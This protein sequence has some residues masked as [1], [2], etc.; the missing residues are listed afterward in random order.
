VIPRG[1]PYIGWTDLLAA[2]FNCLI[3]GDG[4]AARRLAAAVEERWAPNAVAFLSVR[5]G[6]DALFGVLG[7]PAGSEIV[8]SAITIP[9]ILDILAH[10]RLVA[11][12][13]DVDPE[14]LAVDPTD[15]SRA[16]TPSTKAV[17]VAHLFGSRM[18]LD[19]IAE[20]ARSRGVLLLED[21]AQAND[22]SAYRGHASSDVTMFSFGSIKRQTAMGGG[23]LV[24]RDAAL[25][26]R[27]RARHEEYPVLARAAY[28]RRVLTMLVLKPVAFRPAFGSFVMFCRLLGRDHDE[29]LGT[30]LR[31]F[32]HGD[33]FTR[34][35]Q[36]PGAPLL[37]TLDR[38]LREPAQV[39]QASIAARVAV[40]RAVVEEAPE[41]RHVG[42]RAAHHSHWLFPLLSP[43][44]DAL[45]HHL[46]RRGYDATRGASN[47][48]CV[49]APAGRMAPRQAMRL[50]EE[51]LYLPL[52]PTARPHEMRTMARVVRAFEHP[53]A[54]P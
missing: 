13:V 24:F 53:V 10:H 48:C 21:A 1:A 41:L 22:G 5:S 28:L 30:A 52:C 2:T 19:A 27:I 50:M 38:R 7:L 15:V 26:Q 46:W 11:V 4:T 14:T 40:V 33:L 29:V 36:Q 8:I 35:R 12:P 32:S 34:L 18:P 23:L 45:M 31:G 39:R 37:R 3:P 44:P 54:R 42:G 16:I 43:Q 49:S 47:L 17:L 9:H 20:V 51:V 6:L 25:A